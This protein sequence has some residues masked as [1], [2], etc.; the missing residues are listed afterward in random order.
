MDT[1]C[2]PNAKCYIDN[3]SDTDIDTLFESFDLE[4]HDPPISPPT[5]TQ[6]STVRIGRGWYRSIELFELNRML[7]L[8]VPKT[9]MWTRKSAGNFTAALHRSKMSEATTLYFCGLLKLSAA[10][11]TPEPQPDRF[12]LDRPQFP[13]VPD[14]RFGVQNRPANVACQIHSPHTFRQSVRRC[15]CR[16]IV[17]DYV[18]SVAY[19]LLKHP[20]RQLLGADNP[21][22]EIGKA[23]EVLL[24]KSRHNSRKE[25]AKSVYD[26]AH[27]LLKH[28][29]GPCIGNNVMKQ[30]HGHEAV[31]L[32]EYY[33]SHWDAAVK[34]KRLLEKSPNT[35]FQIAYLQSGGFRW[36]IE[37]NDPLALMYHKV[38]GTL[39]DGLSS[40]TPSLHLGKPLQCVLVE[41][42]HDDRCHMQH[43]DGL[44]PDKVLNYLCFFVP[45]AQHTSAQQSSKGV[46][47]ASIE[48]ALGE[49]NNAGSRTETVLSCRVG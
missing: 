31:L 36:T 39:R 32:F 12:D 40:E 20:L 3:N 24:T 22:A 29:R 34:L 1:P 6:P 30:K 38:E 19:C 5:S 14:P 48:R 21:V 23:T 9:Q 35:F 17:L 44:P 41:H 26:L 15:L 25:E 33:S 16:A 18:H 10:Y 45:N 46:A 27:L 13:I 49:L 2:K 37:L 11:E 28:A 43:C 4:R 47:D 7:P 42:I 8:R